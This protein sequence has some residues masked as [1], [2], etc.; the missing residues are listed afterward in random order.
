MDY[1][2]SDYSHTNPVANLN[3][4]KLMEHDD[5]STK[6]PF[7]KNVAIAIMEEVTKNHAE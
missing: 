4:I 5:E 7:K 2:N 3:K 6:I 1:G